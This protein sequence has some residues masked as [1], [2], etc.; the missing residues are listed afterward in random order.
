MGQETELRSPPLVIM[1][2][3]SDISELTSKCMQWTPKTI[4]TLRDV[5]P[6]LK[7]SH[8]YFSEELNLAKIIGRHQFKKLSL[9]VLEIRPVDCS[10]IRGSEKVQLLVDDSLAGELD[11]V[12][13]TF[14][15]RV[16]DVVPETSFPSISIE[17]FAHLRRLAA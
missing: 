17:F 13:S 10:I 6:Q 11:G 8:I 3:T 16:S 2:S 7:A 15:I 1:A 4:V 9:Q 5:V 12:W 14:R